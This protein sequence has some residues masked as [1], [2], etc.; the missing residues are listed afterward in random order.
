MYYMN[1]IQ[2]T[3]VP[4]QMFHNGSSVLSVTPV[5]DDCTTLCCKTLGA[6]LNEAYGDLSPSDYRPLV[7]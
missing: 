4:N 6:G 2:D 3:I 5:T 7:R 1:Y